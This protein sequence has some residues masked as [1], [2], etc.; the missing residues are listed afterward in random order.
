M[1]D[2]NLFVK[3]LKKAKIEFITGVPDSLLKDLCFCFEKKFEK[4][5]IIST[6]EGSAVALGIGHYLAK[7]NPALV[8]MQNSGLGNIINPIASL[9]HPDVYGIPLILV[10]GWRG[11]I[12]NNKIQIQDEPQHKK[13]GKITLKQLKLLNIPYKLINK[14][15]KKV[16]VISL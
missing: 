13:Q 3:G 2:P 6:N 5:H 11:E 1:I 4:N 12:S 7:K 8:Y 16:D 15:T 10:V 9:A 14:N